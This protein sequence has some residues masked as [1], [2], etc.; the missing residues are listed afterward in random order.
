MALRLKH[1]KELASWKLHN[2]RM[3]I[4]LPYAAILTYLLSPPQRL[5]PEFS[6]DEPP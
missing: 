3:Y 6:E 1:I 4:Y 2:T 5:N